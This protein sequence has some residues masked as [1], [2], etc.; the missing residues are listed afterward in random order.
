[1]EQWTQSYSSQEIMMDTPLDLES[2]STNDSINLV[3][4]LQLSRHINLFIIDF[5][6]LSVSTHSTAYL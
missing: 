2:D 1:M 6:D 5:G 3:N 4:A